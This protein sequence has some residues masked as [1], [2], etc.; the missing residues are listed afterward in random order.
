MYFQFQP[1]TTSVNIYFRFP[2]G[3]NVFTLLILEKNGTNAFRGLPIP[4]GLTFLR[5]E[6]HCELASSRESVIKTEH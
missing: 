6:R 4:A 1:I 5:Q 2:A 3:I